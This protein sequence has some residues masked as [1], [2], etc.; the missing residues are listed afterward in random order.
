MPLRSFSTLARPAVSGPDPGSTRQLEHLVD[1]LQRH[2]RLLVL[3]GAGCSTDSGIPDYRDADGNWKH[4]KPVSHRAFVSSERVRRRYW[5]RSAAGWRQFD[6]AGPNAAHHALVRLEQL[7]RIVSLVTQNVDGLHTRAGS[8]QVIDLHGR[9]DRV[10]CLGCGRGDSRHRLQ[11]ELERLN[12][13]WGTIPSVTTP[14]GDADLEDV[15]DRQYDRFRVPGCRGCG[16]I[17]KPAIVFFGDSIPSAR[18]ERAFA[19]LERA[20]ALLVVGSS[21]MVMS[22]YRF[23]LRAA[24]LD[25]PVVIINL[26][27]G[28]ADEAATLKV[29]LPCGEAL[30]SLVAALDVGDGSRIAATSPS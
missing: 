3:T 1:L 19:A 15:T 14:D 9:L 25:I 20:E 5:A 17:L 6:S 30:P 12:P 24:E 23:A 16:G 18:K 2:R 10:V 22:G 7:G 4:R 13:E 11:E 29:A 27:R 26:G 28:R 8:R 21:L